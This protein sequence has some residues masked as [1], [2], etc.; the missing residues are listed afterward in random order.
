MEFGVGEFSTADEDKPIE[1]I[2]IRDT[3]SCRR[4]FFFLPFFC[5][6][7]FVPSLV[8]NWAS[9]PQFVLDEGVA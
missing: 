1:S 8:W 5:F 4:F 9:P 2:R 6:A 7:S 3:E